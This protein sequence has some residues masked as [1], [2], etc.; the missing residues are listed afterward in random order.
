MEDAAQGAR[1]R[2]THTPYDG[3]SQAFTI[4]LRQIEPEAWLTPDAELSAYLAEKR[5]LLATCRETVLLVEEASLPAQREL[6]DWLASHLE[7]HHGGTHRREGDRIH[8]AGETVDLG[9]DPPI[10]AA[11]LLVQED[12]AIMSPSPEGWRLTAAFIA[13]PS[14][15]SLPEKFGRTMDEIHEPVPGF[16]AG[17]R[18]ADLVNRMF[19]RLP[20]DRIVERFNWSINETG[21]LHTP[22]TK[23]ESEAA[24]PRPFERDRTFIRIERQTLRRLPRSGALVFSIRIHADPFDILER[25][26]DAPALALSFM[27]ELEGLSL[28]EAAYKGLASRRAGLVDALKRIAGE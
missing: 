18:N 14:S 21:A 28:P 2:P 11:G 17:T 25:A 6:L 13:F 27:R 1:H 23:A 10:L 4:G 7:A 12:F 15:W 3:R 8:V 16:G 22:K 24:L 20:A 9:T 5:R 19:D 26:P